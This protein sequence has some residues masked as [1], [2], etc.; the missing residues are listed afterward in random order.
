MNFYTKPIHKFRKNL[1][2]SNQQ[3]Q[4][5]N[6]QKIQEEMMKMITKK[7]FTHF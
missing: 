5:K 7:K 2:D 1:F 6:V 4:N 3:H